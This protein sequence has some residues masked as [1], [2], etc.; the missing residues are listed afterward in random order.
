MCV[1]ILTTLCSLVTRPRWSDKCCQKISY[2]IEPAH[3]KS[4]LIRGEKTVF[5]NV[6]ILFTK[7]YCYWSVMVEVVEEGG[8]GWSPR[9]YTSFSLYIIKCSDLLRQFSSL[10]VGSY[11]RYLYRSYFIRFWRFKCMLDESIRYEVCI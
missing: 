6:T 1:K 11:Y 4:A 8:P 10:V 5:C 2:V 3:R 7:A 9:L